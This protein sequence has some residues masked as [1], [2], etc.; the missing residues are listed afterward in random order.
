MTSFTTAV[1]TEN[2]RHDT[3]RAGILQLLMSIC[4]IHGPPVTVR[5][6]PA[7]GFQALVDD[8]YFKEHNIMLDL[9]GRQNKNKNPVLAIQEL[10][11]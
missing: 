9:G 6:D 4:P 5:A 10:Q 3:L 1:I 11:G 2:E 8:P 7:P